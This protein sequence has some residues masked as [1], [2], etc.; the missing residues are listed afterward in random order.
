LLENALIREDNASM[1]NIVIFG[2]GR[3]ANVAT[4]YLQDDSPHHVVAYTA[5]D[6]YAVEKEFMGRPI[7]PFSRIEKEFPPNQVQMFIL[8]GFQRMNALRAEKFA[9]AKAKGYS[10]ANY[11]SSRI[12][13][14]GKLNVGENCFI[15]ESNV[16][17]YDVTIGDNVVM[18]SGNHVGDLSVVEDNVFISSHVVLSGEVR[19]GA[20]SFLGVNAT[21]SNHV[22][23]GP[24]TYVGAN[25]LIA[26]NTPPDSVYVAKGA[27]QLEQ[28]DSLRF[29]QVIR[30]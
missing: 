27:A 29:L 28:I 17:N 13:A 9:A 10:L 5:D 2:I 14:S 1:S 11:V 19:I 25:T 3:G 24:R 22:T 7:V 8:L 21:I 18:W 26:H 4:R 23:V 15:L 20:N 6:V 30:T 12:F 16:F